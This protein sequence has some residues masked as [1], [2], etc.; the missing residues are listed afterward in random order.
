MLL[1]ERGRNKLAR[2]PRYK[3]TDVKRIF[4]LSLSLTLYLVGPRPL[5][6]QGACRYAAGREA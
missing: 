2:V 1:G 6:V 4:N 3:L 5:S